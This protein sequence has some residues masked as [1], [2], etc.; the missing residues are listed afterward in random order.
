MEK[1][2]LNVN[3]R[4]IDL[5]LGKHKGYEEVSAKRKE[6]PKELV[7]DHIRMCRKEK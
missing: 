1:R 6:K 7:K 3:P 2:L 4:F 5:I